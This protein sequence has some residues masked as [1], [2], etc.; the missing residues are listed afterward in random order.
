MDHRI[1]AAALECIGRWSQPAVN[2]YKA[3]LHGIIGDKS[4]RET[5]ALFPVDEQLEDA[6]LPQHRPVVLP[7]LTTLLYA[8]ATA[9]CIVPSIVPCLP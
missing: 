2:K 8:P 1:Q 9:P 6:M 3:Q 4:F 5:L 7:L